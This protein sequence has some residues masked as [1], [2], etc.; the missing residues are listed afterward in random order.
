MKPLKPLNSSC[1]PF[2]HV[3][4]F[5]TKMKLRFS[6]FLSMFCTMPLSAEEGHRVLDGKGL[7]CE[8]SDKKYERDEELKYFVFDKGEV[9]W[10]FV[11]DRNPLTISTFSHGRYISSATDVRWYPYKLDTKTLRLDKLRPT[12]P[13]RQHD[14]EIMDP[15][16]IQTILQEKIE[17]LK[18]MTKED[19]RT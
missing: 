18:N 3:D 13:S 2:I 9:Y 16:R 5:I 10:L 8:V 19:T 7:A 4:G 12:Y 1:Q 14:C 15:K 17:A 6:I 11:T